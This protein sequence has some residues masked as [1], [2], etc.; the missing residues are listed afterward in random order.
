MEPV[1]YTFV[2]VGLNRRNNEVRAP[3]AIYNKLAYLMVNTQPV[4]LKY[5]KSPHNICGY[6]D[7]F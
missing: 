1:P 3:I 7:I 6:T 2:L 5:G 4:P